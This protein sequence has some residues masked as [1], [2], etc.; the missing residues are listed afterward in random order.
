[1]K[2]CLNCNIKFNIKNN[3]CPLC[4][5]KLIGNNGMITKSEINY[6]SNQNSKF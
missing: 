4:Q 2:K 3:Y 1:M 6:C 5:N